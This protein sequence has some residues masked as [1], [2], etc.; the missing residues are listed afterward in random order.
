METKTDHEEGKDV[1]KVSPSENL[2][3]AS[4]ISVPQPDSQPTPLN[5]VGEV[6][7]PDEDDLDD[8]DGIF[9]SLKSYISC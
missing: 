2:P 5:V 4:S 3:E 8:L 1:S 6:P 7:D 9:P